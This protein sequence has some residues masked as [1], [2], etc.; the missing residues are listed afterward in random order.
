MRPIG[1]QPDVAAPSPANVSESTPTVASMLEQQSRIHSA[2]SA[3]VEDILASLPGKPITSDTVAPPATT[4][5]AV[6]SDF[7]DQLNVALS[8]CQSLEEAQAKAASV[9]QQLASYELIGWYSAGGDRIGQ[10]ACLKGLTGDF[11]ALDEFP[12]HALTAVAESSSRSSTTATEQVAGHAQWA[13]ATHVDGLP[14]Q[15]LVGITQDALTAPQSQVLAAEVAAVCLSAWQAQQT[16]QQ[17]QRDAKHVAALVELIG[18]VAACSTMSAAGQC[19][20]QELKRYLNATNVALGLCEDGRPKCRLSAVSQSVKIDSFSESTRVTEAVLQE[21]IARSAATIWPSRD[22]SN[23]HCLLSH[24]HFAAEEN[25]VAVVS[26]PLRNA[27][28]Q[29]VGAILATFDD[30]APATDAQSFVFASERALATSLDSITRSNRTPFSR[31]AAGLRRAFTTGIAKTVGIIAV[32]VIAAMLV[33]MDY[34]V[35][36]ESE[37]QPVSR[38]FIA[39]P[40]DAP[41]EECLVDP[42]DVVEV[43]QVLAL[44]DGR[45][46]RWELAGLRADLGKATKEHNTFL[47]EQKFGEAAI[48]RHEIDRLQNQMSLLTDRTKNLEVR[49]PV[50]G[51]IVAGDLKDTEGV[52]L[53]TGQSLFEV[54]PL[55]RMTV[56]IAIPEED[57]RHVQPGMS[58]RLRLDA[59]PSETVDATILQIHPRAELRDH[60]NVFVAEAELTNADKRLRPGMRGSTKVSTGSRPLGWNL[61]HKPVVYVTGWLGW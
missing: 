4:R 36:C 11:S 41:L 16:A 54:A 27:S 51:V 58:I 37:L 49:S 43:D 53:E 12:Q 1:R 25:A 52:P 8:T 56:E 46:L 22:N 30:N 23:R 7:R 17:S 2:S 44:L 57:V 26:T 31:V 20:T 18:K 15:C 48:A 45:E 6:R 55:D 19:L 29:L 28:G 9:L 10:T 59:L 42:G 50:A 40:F 33:P 61:F 38:R 34:R 14:G 5:S 60:E 32:L 3:R 13:V 24:E 47:S 21:S 39:A 35:T